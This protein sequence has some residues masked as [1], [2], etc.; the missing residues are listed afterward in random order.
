[1]KITA[2][3]ANTD[4]Y[5]RYAEAGADEVFCGYVPES[6]E[7][8]YGLNLPLNRREVR[9]C[10]VQ[11]G[12]E[13]ELRL[14]ASMMRRIGVPVALTFNSPCYRPEQY[15]LLV[16]I[17][18]DCLTLGFRSFILADPGLMAILK[19]QGLSSQ[20]DLHVSGEAGEINRYALA[21]WRRLG[22]NR[23]IFHRHAGLDNMREIILRDQQVCPS[24]P[25][26]YEAFILNEMCHFCGA[27]CSGLHCD[28]LA[29]ICHLPWQ[30]G[31]VAETDP[32]PA[33]QPDIGTDTEKNRE[34]QAGF[35]GCGLCA[36]P[37]LRDMGIDVLKV[38][39]RGADTEEMLRAIRMLRAALDL[40][41]EKIPAEDWPGVL[42]DRLFPGGCSQ[43]CYYS[44]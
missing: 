38:V 15:S 18:S 24:Q 37:Q 20:I 4:Q 23:V 26:N 25:L 44:F 30:C 17:I 7:K 11:I 43:H 41:K 16:Q 6:W 13:N 33:L 10:P 5:L 21:E 28:E 35:D 2:G 19:Q 12:G 3:I 27:Y 29:H 34:E 31:P 39:G 14:L 8:R 36:L 9:Y 32:M 22:A 40:M 1:M 42:R